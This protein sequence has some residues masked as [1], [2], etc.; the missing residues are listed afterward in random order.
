MFS[1]D[2]SNKVSFFLLLLSVSSHFRENC[3]YFFLEECHKKLYS[4]FT[5]HLVPSLHKPLI[6]RTQ[7][8]S[9]C[10]CKKFILNFVL[11]FR[12][13]QNQTRRLLSTRGIFT[14]KTLASSI[15]RGKV[16]LSAPTT[17]LKFLERCIIIRVKHINNIIIQIV[18]TLL[19]C[20]CTCSLNKIK[21]LSQHE[22]QNSG[23]QAQSAKMQQ[24][25]V[26]LHVFI[27]V[28]GCVCP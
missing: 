10:L 24:N 1:L 22:R 3:G 12:L 19:K 2:S 14:V 25:G 5:Q 28:C 27:H 17:K 7:S 23:V 16:S 9:Y 6:L 11:F 8:I 21:F 18:E 20:I 13:L 4:T 15:W 26:C